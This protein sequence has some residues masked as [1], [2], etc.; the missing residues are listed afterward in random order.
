MTKLITALFSI[1]LILSTPTTT[2]FAKKQKKHHQAPTIAAGWIGAFVIVQDSSHFTSP[3]R[4]QFYVKAKA[5]AEA[6]TEAALRQSSWSPEA[7]T[8]A[9]TLP[10]ALTLL[11]QVVP[12][13]DITS[14]QEAG[15]AKGSNIANYE[16]TYK[17]N[18]YTFCWQSL[19]VFAHEPYYIV[20]FA[21]KICD[22]PDPTPTPTPTP[23]QITVQ[24]ANCVPGQNVERIR[25]LE[26]LQGLNFW[27]DRH[28]VA[29]DSLGRAIVTPGHHDWMVR[30]A[31]GIVI[32]SGT[33]N[34]PN[35]QGTPTPT[36]HTPT[37]TP[38]PTPTPPTPTPT[39]TP[40]PTPTPTAT[41]PPTA[42]PTP[43]PTP[44]PHCTF[45]EGYWKNHPEA[46]PVPALRLGTVLYTQAQLLEI[47][48]EPVR[49]NGLVALAHQEI[50]AK[51]N[52]ALGGPECIQPVIDQVDA[53]IG[54]L[55]VPPIGAGFIQ[56]CT[57]SGY[58]DV[59]AN[60]NEGRLEN[61]STH[62]C[63]E[64]RRIFREFNGCIRR[65]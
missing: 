27:I 64:E 8:A 45:S 60:Y 39:P 56:P 62:H 42:T 30:K 65:P 15:R 14:K 32:A 18:G 4:K 1:A 20:R 43:T 3:P 5:E 11:P 63:A 49:G 10:H 46:W 21:I 50:A 23:P 24:A 47:L 2:A 55:V 35:C 13:L 59:L 25:F 53:I 34:V 48:D 54:N 6:N 52:L 7:K 29:L 26:N 33:V 12:G 31:N 22:T 36:L 58:V 41:V 61:C 51:L 28:P 44:P 9:E 40:R 16:G 57:V 19:V 37:A 38:T 17:Q